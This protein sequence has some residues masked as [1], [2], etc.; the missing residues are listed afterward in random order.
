MIIFIFQNLRKLLINS[1]IKAKL[2]GIKILSIPLYDMKIFSNCPKQELVKLIKE[3]SEYGE[4]YGITTIK[5]VI[6]DDES[7]SVSF[8]LKKIYV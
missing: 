3:I 2:I 7:F 8:Q 4:S 1:L 6:S 5:I